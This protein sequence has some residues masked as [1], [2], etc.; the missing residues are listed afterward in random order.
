M[1]GGLRELETAAGETI[2]KDCTLCHAI[3]AQGEATPASVAPGGL[4]FVHPVDIWGEEL[5]TKCTEC[6][7]GGA[8]I[9]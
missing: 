7:E 8:E 6:H 1:L 5:E 4:E 9:Y 3:M 2:S